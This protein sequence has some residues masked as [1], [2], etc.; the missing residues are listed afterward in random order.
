MSDEVLHADERQLRAPGDPFRRLD[1]DEQ[2]PHQPGAVGDRDRIHRV[3]GRV[4]AGH[5]F[6]DDVGHVLHVIARG[7][8]RNDAAV[9]GVE[10]NLG[11]HDV[12]CDSPIFEDEGGAG[13]I[14]RRLDP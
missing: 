8:L 6:A 14:A 3:P 2:R 4:R 1:A 9:L 5:R 10:A 13:L 11:L 7:E 12:T